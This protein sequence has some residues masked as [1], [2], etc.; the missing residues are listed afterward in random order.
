MFQDDNELTDKCSVLISRVR[1]LLSDELPSTPITHL[2]YQQ[3]LS[4]HET[5]IIDNKLEISLAVASLQKESDDELRQVIND[6][7]IRQDKLTKHGIDTMRLE[8]KLVDLRFRI[9]SLRAHIEALDS[10]SWAVRDRRRQ[11]E[12]YIKVIGQV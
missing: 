9:D 12:A 1:A 4:S 3:I 5:E 10:Y 11:S 8:P 6:S 7:T 2:A